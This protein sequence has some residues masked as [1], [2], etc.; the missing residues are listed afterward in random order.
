MKAK[1]LVA[2]STVK[3]VE[4]I[5]S[6]DFPPYLFDTLNWAAYHLADGIY[7][8][9]WKN[10]FTKQRFLGFLLV[11]LDHKRNILKSRRFWQVKLKRN[12]KFEMVLINTAILNLV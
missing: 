7:F 6:K 3:K 11:V 9:E 1:R 12:D 5:T 8:T 2:K 4:Y 10:K